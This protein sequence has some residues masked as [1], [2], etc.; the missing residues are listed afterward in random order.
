MVPDK[1]PMFYHV[2]TDPSGMVTVRLTTDSRGRHRGFHATVFAVSTTDVIAAGI[3]DRYALCLEAGYSGFDCEIPHCIAQNR[4]APPR[5]FNGVGTPYQLGR[6]VS[7]AE[8]LSVPAMPWAPQTGGCV[9]PLA[10]YDGLL[11]GG[12]VAIR[13]V[14]NTPLD[15]EPHPVSAV[16]DKLIIQ[17]SNEGA[18]FFLEQCDSDEV[19]SF[20]WQVRKSIRRLLVGRY[21]SDYIDIMLLNNLFL[22]DCIRQVSADPMAHVSFEPPLRYLSRIQ[23]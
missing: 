7:Q 9:W 4:P 14:F 17:T 11:K 13:L 15:L 23:L 22:C 1:C 8:G 18:E 2:P 3:H 21:C 6:V 10:D 19:C 20:P 16:G 12:I 5:N